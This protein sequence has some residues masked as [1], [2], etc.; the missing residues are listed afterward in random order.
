MLMGI[1]GIGIYYN[2]I[3]VG[4]T[5]TDGI[6]SSFHKVSLLSSTPS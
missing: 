5:I 6:R 2:F 3:I 4:S 1:L